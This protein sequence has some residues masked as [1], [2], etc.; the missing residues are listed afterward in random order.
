MYK[1]PEEPVSIKPVGV[2]V[3]DF[4]K[5]SRQFDY[6]QESMI[7]MRED[8]TRAL[9]GIEYFSHIHVVYFQHRRQDWL[10]M[11]G[12]GSEAEASLTIPFA[13]EPAYQGVYSTRSPARP[14][15]LGYC[16]VELIKRE[17]NRLY[18]RG[19]DAIDGTPVLDVKIYIPHFDA[20]PLAEIPLNWCKPDEPITTSRFLHWDTINVGLTLGLRTGAKALQVLGINRGEAVRAEVVGGHFFA[21]GI[22]GTTGCSPIGGTMI[23]DGANAP[24][25][26]WKLRLIGPDNAVEIRLYERM[27]SEAS[28]VLGLEEEALFAS[29]QKL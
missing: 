11:V 20:F 18:V 16:A 8:L 17:Q 22:E 26:E 13:G 10:E 12:N 28:E 24:M 9:T 25:G 14:S 7:Y 2:V 27:Y 29:V 5:V 23:L 3:S 21:Q 6:N 19:L 4:K 1:I 15:A